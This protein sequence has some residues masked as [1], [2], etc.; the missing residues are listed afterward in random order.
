MQGLGC[1]YRLHYEKCGLRSAV[2]RYQVSQE[3]QLLYLFLLYFQRPNSDF[4]FILSPLW[5]LEAKDH[6]S[7][8]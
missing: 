8:K 6:P 7:I 2:S 5:I 3:S 1:N 4:I